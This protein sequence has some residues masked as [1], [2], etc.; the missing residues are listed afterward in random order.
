MRQDKPDN[1]P[2]KGGW[3]VF[4]SQSRPP[5]G[6]ARVIYSS[7]CL[8]TAPGGILIIIYMLGAGL[9]RRLY[10]TVGSTTT[11][12]QLTEQSVKTDLPRSVKHIVSEGDRPA[13]RS[14][15]H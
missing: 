9:T 15:A 4:L 6:V 3:M 12:W 7:A 5:G 10:G 13:T 1:Q 11:G 2:A 14:R 8:C